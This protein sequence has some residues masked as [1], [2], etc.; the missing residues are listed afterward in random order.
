MRSCRAIGAEKLTLGRSA[1]DGSRKS[2]RRRGLRDERGIPRVS[3]S[4]LGEAYRR[5]AALAG[6]S[7]RRKNAGL[8]RHGWSG[9]VEMRLQQCRCRAD[10]D[11]TKASERVFY[12][13]ILPVVFAPH[14]RQSS[15]G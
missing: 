13:G 12:F 8:C 15:R 2:E 1:L 11:R 14:G 4:W 6:R 5:P 9:A 10:T 3:R 7:A